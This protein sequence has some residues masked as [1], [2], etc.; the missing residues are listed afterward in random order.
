M[1]ALKLFS[2]LTG[3]MGVVGLL[4]VLSFSLLTLNYGFIWQTNS[5]PMLGIVYDYLSDDTL[6]M[7]AEL[8]RIK[9]N[10]FQIICIHFLW[11]TNPQD[12]NRVKTDVLFSKAAQLNLKVYVRQPWSPETLQAYLNVYVDKISYFQV[13]NEADMKLLKEWSVLG[14]LVAVAQKNAETVKTANPNIETVAS[15]ATPLI[16]TL[17]RDISKHVDIIALDI[18]EQIQL[19]TFTF[20]MQTVLTASNK[21]TIWIGEFG[22]AS[23]DDEAQANFLTKGLDT[24]KKNG[25]E[26]A[27]IW[28][29]KHNLSLKIK[30]RQAE[31]DIQ[32]WLEN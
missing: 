20:Q 16:P 7:S 18:Y 8:E 32:N 14:E 26:A 9:A 30:N 27:I 28:C 3:K 29:W 2:V 15:F 22:Y 24:F 4:V 13:I 19:T 6:T 5:E 21:H 25:V 12:P 31:T 11:N 10:G 17:I 23:L 1:N